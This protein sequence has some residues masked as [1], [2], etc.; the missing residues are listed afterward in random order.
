MPNTWVLNTTITVQ[1]KLTENEPFIFENGTSYFNEEWR[2]VNVC[3][4]KLFIPRKM[5]KYTI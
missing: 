4:E 1:V 3:A 5:Y 2:F